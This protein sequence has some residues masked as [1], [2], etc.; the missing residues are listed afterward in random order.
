VC[1]RETLEKYIARPFP[2]LTADPYIQAG[3][4]CGH[5]CDDDD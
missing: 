5:D 1:S 2:I 4:E 3:G